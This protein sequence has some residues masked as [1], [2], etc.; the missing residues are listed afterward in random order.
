LPTP[1][2]QAIIG[3]TEKFELLLVGVAM[4]CLFLVCCVCT[5]HYRLRQVQ[6]LR[7]VVGRFAATAYIAPR[8]HS[9]TWLSPTYSSRYCI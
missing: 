5:M 6:V 2:K 9:P 8:T 7:V 4:A 1:P 3:G